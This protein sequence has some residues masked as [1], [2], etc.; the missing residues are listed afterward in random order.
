MAYQEIKQLQD[1]VT[2]MEQTIE[3]VSS[4]LQEAKA[5]V[6]S[7][8]DEVKELD[9]QQRV[10][11]ERMALKDK[12]LEAQVGVNERLLL[13]QAQLRKEY[14][15]LDTKHV[16]LR[17]QEFDKVDVLK[18]NAELEGKTKNLQIDLE[19]LICERNKLQDRVS[20]LEQGGALAESQATQATQELDFV[21]RTHEAAMDKFEAKFAEFSQELGELTDQNAEMKDKERKL[22]RTVNKLEVANLEL[23]EKLKYSQQRNNDLNHQVGYVERDMHRLAQE[24]GEQVQLHMRTAEQSQRRVDATDR[25][26]ADI[27]S[28]ISQFRDERNSSK[29]RALAASQR[30]NRYS[31][32]DSRSPGRDFSGD[33]GD[34]VAHAHQLLQSSPAQ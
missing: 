4:E 21:R 9:R 8:V 13:E 6:S 1:L 34:R 10:H 28:M 11:E 2:E 33:A 22:K 7:R 12:E 23:E 17:A 29:E 26:F 5:Q 18:V 27:K 3:R 14:D 16:K 15:E 31:R 32:E 25:A 30:G 20:Q 24:T 19:N